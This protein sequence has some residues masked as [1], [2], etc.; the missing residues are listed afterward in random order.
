[1]PNKD[2]ERLVEEDKEK[3]KD[4]SFSTDTSAPAIA[5]GV[6]IGLAGV[7]CMAWLVALF[8]VPDT[9]DGT[10]WMS[11][12]VLG[13]LLTATP[14]GAIYWLRRGGIETIARMI[15]QVVG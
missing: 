8:W 15:A 9:I 3:F 7:V 6:L 1:M 4:L 12:G 11:L 10:T 2:L 13:L 14:A 5:E